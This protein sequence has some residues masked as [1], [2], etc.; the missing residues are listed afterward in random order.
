MSNLTRRPVDSATPALVLW[1][2]DDAIVAVECRAERQVDRHGK[3]WWRD[4]GRDETVERVRLATGACVLLDSVGCPRPWTRDDETGRVLLPVV[5]V[6]RLV[7]GA[8][9]WRKAT[10]SVGEV[11]ALGDCTVRGAVRGAHPFPGGTV[12]GACPQYLT[13]PAR[14]GDVLVPAGSA[15][16]AS[17][18]PGKIAVQFP[19]PPD[20]RDLL[21][22]REL[23]RGGGE[24]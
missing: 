20:V 17:H 24:P 2:W 4:E 13:A 15:I 22:L 14:F 19:D 11:V 16:W 8:V 1:L 21:V 12:S 7:D 6:G 10:T 9:G 23:R 3:A 18:V 5:A